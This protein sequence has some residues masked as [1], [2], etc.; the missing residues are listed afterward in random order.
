[1]TDDSRRKYT[2]RELMN[3]W[4]SGFAGDED[5]V[6]KLAGF[7][8]CRVEQA[9]AMIE[10]FRKTAAAQKAAEAEANRMK[11]PPREKKDPAPDECRE[12]VEIGE[13]FPATDIVAAAVNAA[14]GFSVVIAEALSR[15]RKRS[16]LVERVSYHGERYYRLKTTCYSH[17]KSKE[18]AIAAAKQHRLKLKVYGNE[19][20][21]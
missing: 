3:L 11:K 10:S 9:E 18:Q 5:E 12:V 7:A 14:H 8:D 16:V 19:E 20:K 17:F 13:P 6:E 4:S 2:R 15:D 21:S 1:M